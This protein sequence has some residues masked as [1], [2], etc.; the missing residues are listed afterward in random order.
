MRDD[1]FSAGG[2]VEILLLS[3][4]ALVWTTAC[5]SGGEGVALGGV[6]LA[7]EALGDAGLAGSFGLG[8]SGVGLGECGVV[9]LGECGVVGLGEGSEEGGDFDRVGIFEGLA[10]VDCCG[11]EATWGMTTSV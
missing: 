9:G 4:A 1:L 6:T 2:L 8:P 11:L 5:G 3:A 7:C 10:G